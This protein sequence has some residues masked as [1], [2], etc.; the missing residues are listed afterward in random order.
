MH[1]LPPTHYPTLHTLLAAVPFNGYFARSVLQHHVRGSVFVDSVDAPHNAYILHPYGMS[2]LL[3]DGESE[4][5]KKWLYDY[6][7]NTQGQ[8]QGNEWMQVSSERWSGRIADEL[9]DKLLLAEHNHAGCYASTI[10]VNSR[11]NFEF[12]AE[13]YHTRP[14]LSTPA[15]VRIERLN[16]DTVRSM[17][18]SVIPLAFWNST[19]EFIQHS[20]GYSVFVNGEQASTAYAAFIHDA[21]LEIGIETVAA[22]RGQGHAQRCCG[23]LIDYCLQEGRTPVWSCRLENRGSYRLALSLGFEPIREL[24][25]YRLCTTGGF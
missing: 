11:V 22:F 25:Y 3:G 16:A 19:E 23:A 9:G 2:L 21:I 20:I 14:P 1:L 13:R 15:G 10:E 6:M 5:F 17:H 7:L 8:R 4:G 18:G 12:N 24:P